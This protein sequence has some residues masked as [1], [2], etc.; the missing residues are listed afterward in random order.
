MKKL[1]ICFILLLSASPLFAKFDPAF[2]WTTL[3]TPHF[4][5]HFHQGEEEIAKRAAVIAEDAH[6]RLSPRIQW[7]PKSRTHVV[8]VD[9]V[10]AS[11]GLT[12]VFPYNLI[13]LYITPPVGEPGF[14]TMA[15]DEWMRVLITHEYTHILH[16]DMV[17][18]P[19]SV[20]RDIF[21]RIYFPNAFEP[22]WMIEGLAV[23]EE[24]EQTSG[25]RG[26]SP[27]SEAV[28]RMAVL[29]D[30][31]PRLGQ[32]AVF[33]DFWPAGQV[34]YLFGESFTRFIAE[35][36]GREKLADI[37]VR[38]SY[39]GV[40]WFVDL[41]GRRTLGKWYSDLWD[42]WQ[43][44]LKTRYAKIRDELREKGLTD[45]LPLTRRGYLNSFPGF[46]PDGKRIAYVVEN[47]DE[48]PGIYVMNS[49]GTNDRKLVENTTAG[50]SSGGSI[51]WSPDGNRI[52]YT[53][54]DVQKNVNLY[55]DIYYYDLRKGKE[56]RVTR[57]VRARDPYPSPDGKK[58]VFVANRLGRTRL[59]ALDLPSGNNQLGEKDLVYL[60]DESMNQYETPRYNPDGAMIVVGVWQPG[61]YKDIWVLDSGGSKIEELMHDRAID[62]GA[63]WSPDGKTIYFASDRTGIFNLYACEL[64][65]K[66]IY[67][68]TNVL[69]GAFTPAPSPDGKTIAFSS[70]S[71]TGFDIHTR[72]AGPAAWKTAP[73]YQDP[74]PVV[75]HADKPVE[76]KTS[77]Y[78]PLP[79]LLPR[80]WIPWYGYSEESRD[81]FGF[82]T[83]G[84]D[85][86]ERHSYMLTGLYS[87]KTYR[88]WYAFSYAYDGLYPT[89]QF[90]ASDVDRTFSDLLFD[91][92]ATK[93]YVQRQRTIG[94]SLTFPLLK[95]QSQ[96]ELVIGYRRQHIS[97]LT[98]L[99]PW[100]GYSGP[101]P[102]QGDLTSGR[103]SYLFNSARRYGFSISPEEGR[104][105]ELGY[106][107]FDKSLGGDFNITKYTADWH[108]YINFPWKHHV[109]L[110]RA[111]AGASSGEVIPQGAFQ[112]GGD[113]PGDVTIPV[114]EESVY[115]RGYKINAFRGRKA[116]LASLEYRFPITDIETGWS[117][118]PVFLRRL[119]GAAFAEAGNVWDNA[120]RSSEFKRAIGA[121]LRLDTDLAYYLPITF[122][123]VIAKGLDDKGESQ[124]YLSLWMP[125]VF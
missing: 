93:D 113:N 9:A 29:E 104:T 8:L 69:G 40:P 89:F 51:A 95:M 67:Q 49:D 83:F 36:Y 57:G 47:A 92:T 96:H 46:S 84:Q 4:Y 13:T 121:E 73:P 91:P 122:R 64:A 2:T 94:A 7:E 19:T 61:G 10:D 76:A 23:Y 87:P 106:E 68:I 59:A 78:N 98:R 71:S 16:L 115:L 79:T 112:I 86:V 30:R 48:F 101:V 105:I 1:L 85:A 26:R 11:N 45:S 43:N 3:E 120:F 6:A 15:Y 118:T 99:P 119:H 81:L 24:T 21:G 125:M 53:K 12:T 58:L 108:E 70:Y 116:A 39:Y 88:K 75:A 77:G 52:Y 5:I 56:V 33:P 35:K 62:G 37:S 25:G 38:Y 100:P 65:S 74:Y 27:G 107:R 97:A 110:A 28:I 80:F 32:A 22:V 17:R 109:L 60:T 31:F 111:F 41:N 66:K 82:L 55:N 114:D 117:N 20:L 34:P 14:G 103:V 54:F 44:E 72:S 123:L 50:T 90:A 63:A 42:E 124:F 18:G 102:A